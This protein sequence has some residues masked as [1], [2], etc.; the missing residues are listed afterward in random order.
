MQP[1]HRR[2][3]LIGG[4]VVAVI[5]VAIVAV[6]H[7]AARSVKQSIEEAL[8]PEGEA[9]EITVRLTSIELLD[10][11]IAAPN[12]WPSD[13]ALR[14]K[15]VVIVPELRHVISDTIQVTSI[16]VEDGYLSALRPPEGGGLRV[17]PSLAARAKKKKAA[18][19]ERRGATV[20]R[21]RLTN[22]VVEVFDAT[23][24]GKPNKARI[25]AVKG[26]IRDIKVPEL[27]SRTRVDLDGAIKGVNR[28]GTVSIRGWVEV[29]PKKAELQ[30]QV[31]NVDLALFEPY[32]LTKL[33]SGIDSGTFN[34][35]L[36][37]TVQNNTVRAPGTLTVSRLK[38]KASENPIE[39]ISGLP[40]GA[41]LGAMENEQGEITV[42][43]TL[44]GNLDD[45]TF[46]LTGETG[47]KTGVAVAKAFGMSFEGLARALL[48]ILNGFGSAFGAL[49][50]G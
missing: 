2:W 31:R 3:A 7:F 30:T 4:A 28:N 1:K 46:S 34:M 9:A 5:A 42:P 18:G 41:A 45:P 23:T 33:K 44:E 16:E 27:D 36:K 48:I 22:T 14:A 15:R 17:L 21:V 29:A 43:F 49:V 26:T 35:D 25:D 39:A 8:G 13:T 10:V 38:L 6:L 50:P 37:S 12:G 19:E 20:D 40:R 32:L 24:A 11:R 47:L